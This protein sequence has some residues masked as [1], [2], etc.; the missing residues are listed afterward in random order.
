MFLIKK[1]ITL[2]LLSLSLQSFTQENDNLKRF[3]VKLNTSLN[4][5]T[6]EDIL[7]IEE[8]KTINQLY[9][10]KV[11][12]AYGFSKLQIDNFAKHSKSNH[13]LKNTFRIET[14][15]NDTASKT[16]LK[17]LKTLPNLVYAYQAN[18][19]P[20]APP[21]DIAP[22]TSN[23]ESNQNY[24]NANPGL[25][26]EYA[27]NLNTNGA[28]IN[29]RA[30]EYGINLAHE[31]LDHTTAALPENTTINSGATLNFTE[32][33]T[34]VAG[35]V[36]ADKGTYGI[37]GIA[38]GA[39]EYIL[40]PEWTEEYNYNRVLATSNAIANSNAGDIV[41]YEMQTYGQNDN[42][43]LAEY[44]QAIWDLTKAATDAGIIIVAAAGNGSEN[45]DDT[46]YNSYLARGDSGAIIVGAGTPNT[47]HAPYGYSTHGS[48]VDVQ[49]W[50]NLAYTIGQS[51]ASLTVFGNDLNQTYNSCFSGTSSATA[52][53]GGF[54]AVL[55][56]YYLAETGNFLTSQDMR[57]LMVNTGIPQGSGNNIGPL[58]NM[59]TAI[60][61]INNTLSN[62]EYGVT[63]FKM[64]P[65]PAKNKLNIELHTQ[66]LA[67][68]E[69]CNLLGQ[70]VL[71]TN[72][73]TSKKTIV[74][75]NILKGLYIV[76]LKTK[77]T[78]TTK[79]LIIN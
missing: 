15:L 75:D 44:E 11:F 22:T 46:F 77:T 4:F 65:N 7:S 9:P 31:E 21:H 43:V 42:F 19:T 25:N 79:K 40:Y 23:L 76:T 28:G 8:I 49:G 6:P 45:L 50:G 32:H 63:E 27:W 66:E 12:K 51:C 58:P 38:H 72:L 74:L 56:S 69:I 64:Y 71:K 29:I 17:K 37:S 1:S 78:T 70:Q 55:Q 60:N 53:I 73:K 61:S 14:V 26:I 57:T 62:E 47:N 39:N 36:F 33:G 68:L 35:I 20:I 34:S 41:I 52:I 10:F 5:K 13:T 16:F 18:T 24:L 67:A 2:I 59:E 3:Y 54:A 48:R 30:I